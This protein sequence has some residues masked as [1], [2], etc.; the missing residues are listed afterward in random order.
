MLDNEDMRATRRLGGNGFWLPVASIKSFPRWIR[1]VAICSR[2]G[3]FWVEEH[4]WSA[5][6][7]NTL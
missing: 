2:S 7:E 5:N 4:T 6:T 1:A 3:L